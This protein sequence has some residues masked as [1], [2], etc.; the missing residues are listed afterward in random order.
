MLVVIF[1]LNDSRKYTATH[2]FD[3]SPCLQNSVA[4]ADLRG[5]DEQQTC[6]VKAI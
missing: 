2:F 1:M 6:Q 5:I 4:N 3:P